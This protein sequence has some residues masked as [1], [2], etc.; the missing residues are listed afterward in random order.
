MGL[1]FRHAATSSL[2][3]GF[4]VVESVLYFKE[5]RF[6]VYQMLSGALVQRSVKRLVIE[7]PRRILLR[8]LKRV[9]PLGVLI[10][11]VIMYQRIERIVIKEVVNR[12]IIESCHVLE[13]V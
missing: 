8:V 13:C 12:N 10:R 9:K 4:Y 1:F 5:F 3:I 11:C 6:L 2:Q 7:N